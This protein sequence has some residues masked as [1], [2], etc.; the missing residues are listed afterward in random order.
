M[1]WLKWGGDGS[2]LVWILGGTEK[3]VEETWLWSLVGSI[4]I[5]GGS[6]SVV[7]DDFGV[8]GSVNGFDVGD[9][10][11]EDVTRNL[12]VGSRGG[13]IWSLEMN[14]TVLIV[15]SSCSKGLCSG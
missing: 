10:V 6:L 5:P 8:V 2:W 15:W 12:E 13:C 3:P 7:S 9:P 14:V 11:E 1:S 4:S